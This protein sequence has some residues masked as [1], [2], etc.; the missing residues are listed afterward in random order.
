MTDFAFVLPDDVEYISI[1][2]RV[3]NHYPEHLPQTEV[4]ISGSPRRDQFNRGIGPQYGTAR[5]GA[6]LQHLI[7]TAILELRLRESDKLET[8]N[9]SPPGKVLPPPAKPDEQTT[10][11]LNLLGL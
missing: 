10:D 3:V 9:A 1:R 8:A 2:H 7:E 4:F 11:L 6:P 5:G